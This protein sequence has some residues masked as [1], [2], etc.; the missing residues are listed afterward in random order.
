MYSIQS[1]K[2]LSPMAQLINIKL[3]LEPVNTV[4]GQKAG[5]RLFVGKPVH[6]LFY[7]PTI[8]ILHLGPPH[9]K[10]G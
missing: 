1:F 4:P 9:Y 10:L 7:Q 6:T 3:Q 5:H 8:V 2:E